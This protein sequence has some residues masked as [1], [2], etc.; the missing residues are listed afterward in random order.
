LLCR[1]PDKEVLAAQ[2]ANPTRTFLKLTEMRFG[3]RDVLI[4]PAPPG[5]VD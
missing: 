4:Q 1:G 2:I 3:R 5:R